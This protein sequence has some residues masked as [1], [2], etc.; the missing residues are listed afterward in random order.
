MAA[1]LTE[2]E[3]VDLTGEGVQSESD[4]AL[5]VLITTGVE[6]KM[7]SLRDSLSVRERWDVVNYV[8]HELVNAVEVAAAPQMARTPIPTLIPAAMPTPDLAAEAA[9]QACSVGA[10][11]LIGA[12]VAAGYSE[13]DPFEFTDANTGETCVGVF[14]EDVLPLFTEANLWFPGA[15]SCT[16]CHNADVAESKANL[17]MSSYEGVLAGSYREGPGPGD[18][19]LEAGDWLNSILYEMLVSGDMP[20]GRPPDLPVDEHGP[21]V[22]AG[23]LP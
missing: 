10:I 21:V 2:H 19:I 13:S 17:D 18:D 16:A 22:P 5:F 7:P 6:E 15:K 9:A 23:H 1:Y 12:W 14:A 4:G 11:D 8:K 20:Q 3:P